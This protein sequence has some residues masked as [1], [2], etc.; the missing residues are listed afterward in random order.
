MKPLLLLFAVLLC[1][2]LLP[3]LGGNKKKKYSQGELLLEECWG[4]P[5]ANDCTKRCSRTFKCVYRNHTC[6]WTYCGN[7]CAEIGKFFERKK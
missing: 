2:L 7:I 3:A 4:Q 5:K 1:M 6:C